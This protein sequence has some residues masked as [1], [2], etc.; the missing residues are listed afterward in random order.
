MFKRID[1]KEWQQHIC[2]DLSPIIKLLKERCGIQVMKV[3]LENVRAPDTVIYLDRDIPVAVIEA[4]K[5]EFSS[6]SNLLFGDKRV[7]CKEH[8]CEVG[9]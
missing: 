8:Y 6:N 7:C 9:R 1:Q 2:D 4:L 3:G 5:E